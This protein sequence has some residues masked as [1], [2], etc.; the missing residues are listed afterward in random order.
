MPSINYTP[1]PTIRDFM[2]SDARARFIRGPV[3]SG[4]TT[5]MIME[6]L[7]RAIQQTPCIDGIRRSRW[8]VTRLTMPQL[9]DTVLKSWLQWLPDGEFGKFR[10][11]DNTYILNFND[12][13]CEV[14]FR[15]L[16]SPADVS[17][18]LSLELT[19]AWIAECRDLPLELVEAIM[20]RLG[21]YPSRHQLR[22]GDTYWYGMIG[23]TNPPVEGTDWWKVFEH[24][25][26][27][28][29]NMN[30]VF[31]C[32]T[33]VQPCPVDDELNILPEAENAE[34]LPPTYYQDLCKGKTDEFIRVYVRNEYGRSKAGLPVYGDS[35]RRDRHVSRRP[36]PIDPDLP[37]VIGMDF[38]L[39]SALVLCQPLVVEPRL[40]ILREIT[41]EG[42][43]LNS[44]IE[45]RLRP[46][47]RGQ[48]PTNPVIII[49]DPAGLNRASTDGRNCYSVLTKAGF[50]A[51][52]ARTNDPVVRIGAL[53]ELLLS[54]PMGEP[55]L[56]IDPSCRTLIDGLMGGYMFRLGAKGVSGRDKSEKPVKNKVGH[57]VEAAQY[58][59]MYYL[60]GYNPRSASRLAQSSLFQQHYTP[61]DAYTGY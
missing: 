44:V 43:S 59:C 11:S 40:N 58:A 55:A 5:G 4:K 1:P 48:F 28:E 52:P 24:K 31:A 9:K 57:T 27:E 38:G 30:S 17:R 6:I 45:N 53:E 7:R 56:R 47:L 32:D 60:S 22:P 34:N 8:L 18:V 25:P 3:G 42:A 37:I 19:G 50:T 23:E 54:Y 33:F 13:E 35:F 29:G 41:W 51:R 21:R 16:E 20:G 46:L 10:V 2:R 39:T 36:L 61:A 15:P 49:G 14:L 26:L 12:V